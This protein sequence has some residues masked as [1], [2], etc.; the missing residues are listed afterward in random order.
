MSLKDLMTV[1]IVETGDYVV[2]THKKLQDLYACMKQ[3][4]LT[5]ESREFVTQFLD[6]LNEQKDVKQNLTRPSF[7]FK[8]SQYVQDKHGL[9]VAHVQISQALHYITVYILSLGQSIQL[10]NLVE[11]V[12]S[13]LIQQNA[14]QEA[15]RQ[16]SFTYSLIANPKQENL[17]YFHAIKSIFFSQLKPT[18]NVKNNM[19]FE[20]LNSMPIFQ[21]AD[22][23]REFLKQFQAQKQLYSKQKQIVGNQYQ[24]T[25][26]SCPFGDINES[27]FVSESNLIEINQMEYMQLVDQ[28][29]TWINT[30]RI[31]VNESQQGQSYLNGVY[32]K[33]FAQCEEL[34]QYNPTVQFCLLVEQIQSLFVAFN[35]YKLI[36][37]QDTL[38]GQFY[39]LE[40]EQ[41]SL[42]T[43][44]S[45]INDLTN[46]ALGLLNQ[47]FFP[48]EETSTCYD[49]IIKQFL[50]KQNF[51]EK[52]LRQGLFKLLLRSQFIQSVNKLFQV[53]YQSVDYTIQTNNQPLLEVI[54]EK[55]LQNLIYNKINLIDVLQLIQTVQKYQNIEFI[56]RSELNIEQANKLIQQQIS[57]SDHAAVTIIE[58][59]KQ[60]VLK[61]KQNVP[62]Q[63]VFCELIQQST[64]QLLTNTLLELI[65]SK[66]YIETSNEID[67]KQSEEFVIFKIAFSSDQVGF[68]KFALQFLNQF[69]LRVLDAVVIELLI[70]KTALIF[71]YSQKQQRVFSVPF[72]CILLELITSLTVEDEILELLCQVIQRCKLSNISMFF[73]QLGQYSQIF[74]KFQIV[75][76]Q[77]KSLAGS[78]LQIFKQYDEIFYEHTDFASNLRKLIKYDLS[79]SQSLQNEKFYLQKLFEFLSDAVQRTKSNEVLYQVCG[80]DLEQVLINQLQLFA[81]FDSQSV[82]NALLELL[83]CYLTFEPQRSSLFEN[84]YA[85][86][87]RSDFAQLRNW[88][89]KL[90]PE[91][92]PVNFSFITVLIERDLEKETKVEPIFSLLKSTLDCLVQKQGQIDAYN[93]ILTHAVAILHKAKNAVKNGL[94]VNQQI[95]ADA[96]RSVCIVDQVL[97]YDVVLLLT[98]LLE[99]SY[100]NQ[101]LSLQFNLMPEVQFIASKQAALLNEY[102]KYNAFNLSQIDNFQV[103]QAVCLLLVVTQTLLD[104]PC[105]YSMIITSQLQF[106]H[107]TKFSASNRSIQFISALKNKFGELVA[108]QS[109]DRTSQVQSLQMPQFTNEI[110]L[111]VQN[112]LPQEQVMS[113]NLKFT[114]LIQKRIQNN[115]LVSEFFNLNQ[116]FLSH[117]G[118]LFN[119]INQF[120]EFDAQFL[121]GQKILVVMWMNLKQM[122]ENQH[123]HISL[124]QIKRTLSL[125][126]DN[127]TKFTAG[128]AGRAAEGMR[129]AWE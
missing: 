52:Q 19:N 114:D 78:I 59:A 25:S 32:I 73:N 82:Q 2:N 29:S 89:L 68:L 71:D 58:L 10:D 92:L 67:F 123:V 30:S 39:L 104:D 8:F 102:V 109:L 28:I 51:D 55:S 26:I 69:F 118:Q 124:Q 4:Q 96:I 80:R 98:Q 86:L 54:V 75:L 91:L 21:F 108:Q 117:L 106:L 5:G 48:L 77:N 43:I 128:M 66:T 20:Y 49:L 12:Q 46:T 50:N 119:Q 3:C 116:Q 7:F 94:Q 112:Q 16:H 61:I 84:F 18:E 17:K 13:F 33:G 85:D 125:K 22:L 113:L 14:P 110:Q 62:P 126:K 24:P 120:G 37:H 15:L 35:N 74:Q 83:V 27:D 53:S 38:V 65:V 47:I 105:E 121:L 42:Q 81:G 79:N 6:S 127:V 45:K 101:L 93:M 122:N 40:W 87:Q 97:G 31:Q 56:Q 76:L 129:K 70:E 11:L 103:F 1:N 34:K 64:P 99:I 41:L 44:L 107:Q 9:S 111:A 88:V 72:W 57:F 23:N 63:Q 95:V 60:L 90:A 100:F 36:Q 115:S